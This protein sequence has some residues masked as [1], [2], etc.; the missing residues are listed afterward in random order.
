M[1]SSCGIVESSK[2]SP[3]VMRNR[4]LTLCQEFSFFVCGPPRWRLPNHIAPL[5]PRLEL[6]FLLT[7]LEP[8]VRYQPLALHMARTAWHWLV[9]TWYGF[10]LSKLK[11]TSLDGAKERTQSHFA[12]SHPGYPA[13]T[14][15]RK[16]FFKVFQ[17]WEILLKMCLHSTF[18]RKKNV[19]PKIGGNLLVKYQ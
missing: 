13:S 18:S 5:L 15:P 11:S 12:A 10:P 6:K 14:L 9:Q 1:G 3:S 2:V 4:N 16:F 19:P 8:R 7:M 17:I